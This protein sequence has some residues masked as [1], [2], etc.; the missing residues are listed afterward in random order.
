MD[1]KHCPCA[2]K[3]KPPPEV[4]VSSSFCLWSKRAFT[5]RQPQKD[6]TT[7]SNFLFNLCSD[8]NRCAVAVLHS[9]LILLFYSANKSESRPVRCRVRFGHVEAVS[10]EQRAAQHMGFH[11]EPHSQDQALESGQKRDLADPHTPAKQ[12]ATRDWFPS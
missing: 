2:V 4:P 11:N 3:R 10:S 8:G 9:R 6:T 1:S 5:F 12:Y 7:A